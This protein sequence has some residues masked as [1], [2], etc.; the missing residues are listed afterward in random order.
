MDKTALVGSDLTSGLDVVTEL[1]RRGVTVD[2]AAW[3]QDDETSV[4][5]LLISTPDGTE[6]GAR[7]VYEA[8][9]AILQELQIR[10]L[11]LDNF[12]VSG[13]HE[14]LVQ[15]LKRR[16]GT[17]NGLHEI[18]LDLLGIGGKLYRSSRIHRVLGDP[19]DNGARVRVK[20]SGQLG[21]VRG[22]VR[23]PRGPR[24]LVVYDRDR[25][26]IQPLDGE[27]RPPV[28]QDYGAEDLDFLYVVRTGGWPERIPQWLADATGVSTFTGT[29][30]SSLPDQN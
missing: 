19:I 29:A 24:Y 17:D 7:P 27:H 8:I 25:T 4:W 6:T 2:V 12:L 14:S 15:D 26:D 1:E 9:L 21:T 23:T 28:G 5:K 13:P 20:A 30:V 16:V 11:D 18:R 22:V 10:D 3:L